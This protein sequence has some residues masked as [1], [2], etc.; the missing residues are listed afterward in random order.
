MKKDSAVAVL[1]AYILYTATTGGVYPM[2]GNGK[3]AF[4]AGSL[5]NTGVSPGLNAIAVADLNSDGYADLVLT[6]KGS[7]TLTMIPNGL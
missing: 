4:T 1:D 2:T 7:A 5:V 6:N 3:G